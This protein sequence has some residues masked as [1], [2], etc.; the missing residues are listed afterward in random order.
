M[1]KKQVGVL[2]MLLTGL[3]AGCNNEKQPNIETSKISMEVVEETDEISETEEATETEVAVMQDEFTWEKRHGGQVKEDEKYRYIC[4]TSRIYKVDKV[5][6]KAEILWEQEEHPETAAMFDNGNALLVGDRIYFVE[7]KT[8]NEAETETFLSVIHT[9]GTGYRTLVKDLSLGYS[10][11]F[12]QD[13]LLFIANYDEEY[14]YKILPDGRLEK[15]EEGSYVK[16]PEGYYCISYT[17]TGGHYLSAAE[18]MEMYGCILAYD[19]NYEMV[20]IWE[21]GTIKEIQVDGLECLNENW[22][23]ATEFIEGEKEYQIWNS[24]TWESKKLSFCTG[25]KVPVIIGMDKEYIYYCY[26]E[27]NPHGSQVLAVEKVSIETQESERLFCLGDNNTSGARYYGR[28]Y[29]ML[30]FL[31]DSGCFYYADEEDYKMYVKSRNLRNIE[32]EEVLTPA[33]YE[34]GIADVGHTENYFLQIFSDC[35]P[36]VSLMQIQTELLVIDG[37]FAGAEKINQF[38]QEQEW[39]TITYGE[40]SAKDQERCIREGES[41][42]WLSNYSIDSFVPEISYFDERYFS[43]YQ[44][45]YIYQGGAHGMPYHIGYT[46]DLQTGKLLELRDIVGNSEEELKEIITGYGTEYVNKNPEAFWGDAVGLIEEYAGFDTSFYLDEKGIVFYYE[47]YFLACYAEGFK[48][49][50]IPFEEFELK[51]PLGGTE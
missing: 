32:T 13:D 19:T 37:K 50:T 15:M 10:S 5:S 46:F 12:L 45:E 6:G 39:N 29:G 9:N 11:L 44:Q 34:S 36:E 26:N 21:D 16:L 24:K 40:E 28:E 25:G 3:L 51:I 38:L 1:R 4:S 35:Q 20:Q 27:E 14:C 30:E 8:G 42:E 7:E 23:L 18:S 41:Y 31:Q 33:F 43:F 17:N 49:V 2:I 47:P 48:E 22:L